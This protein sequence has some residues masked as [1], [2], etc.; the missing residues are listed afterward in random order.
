MFKL[1]TFCFLFVCLAILQPALAHAVEIPASQ[2]NEQQTAIVLKFGTGDLP[3]AKIFGCDDFAWG[4]FTHNNVMM[5]EYVP[6][7]DN[8][9]SW[10]KMVTITLHSLPADKASQISA[11][12]S[13][14]G[15]LLQGYSGKGRILDQQM[16]TDSKGYPRMFVEYEIGEG[17]MKEHNAGTYMLSGPT[18]AAFIQTQARN[19]ELDP[20]NIS[21]MKLIAEGKRPTLTQN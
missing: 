12:Q 8:V 15:T 5:L 4:S 9:N 10:T 6:N 14:E 19:T 3:I 2:N 7:G 16:Y 21:N 1:L 13:M 20:T 18:L 11:M 17:L